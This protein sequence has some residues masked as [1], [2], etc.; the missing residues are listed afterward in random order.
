MFFNSVIFWDFIHL[1]EMYCLVLQ[2]YLHAQE[3]DCLRSEANRYKHNYQ[4]LSTQQICQIAIRCI[5]GYS[6]TAFGGKPSLLRY[7]EQPQH[8]RAP[9]L[10]RLGTYSHWKDWSSSSFK[11]E[12]APQ[13]FQLDGTVCSGVSKYFLVFFS[14]LACLE[15]LICEAFKPKE[16]KTLFLVF[17]VSKLWGNLDSDTKRMRGMYWVDVW[18]LSPEKKKVCCNYVNY[19]RCLKC[20]F[21]AFECNFSIT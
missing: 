18:T 11:E 3:G 20:W 8:K 7:S 6:T 10:V 21:Q 16:K 19:L 12:K 17:H 13:T 14:G 2:G 1:Y 5:N 9:H 15:L 4:S